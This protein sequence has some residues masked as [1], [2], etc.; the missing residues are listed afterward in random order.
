[1]N[2]SKNAGSARCLKRTTSEDQFGRAI[3]LATSRA[4]KLPTADIAKGVILGLSNLRSMGLAFRE[5]DYQAIYNLDPLGTLERLTAASES[6]Y[7]QTHSLS[8]SIA[9]L[10]AASATPTLEASSFS[11]VVDRALAANHPIAAALRQRH[12][13]IRLL[14]WLGTV[15]NKAVQ[16]RAQNGYI[17][18]MAM[19]ARDAFVLFRNPSEPAPGV[20]SAARNYLT[21]LTR[22]FSIPLDPGNGN[23][24]AVAYLDAV[25]HGLLR[26]H[27]PQADRA[28]D[29]VEKA[30]QH[31]VVM[32]A[33]LLDN[34]AWALASL[35]E[36]V[37]EHPSR[38]RTDEG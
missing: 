30:R 19:M 10:I 28:R 12:R 23:R 35:I 29:I 15:R 31:D 7:Q 22:A 38:F 4:A 27:Q 20:A 21:A 37:P 5:P 3:A 9:H 24:E 2:R 17:D 14:R 18:N 34:V 36:V 25:S 11:G 13:E 1:V 8:E 16:H 32:S 6:A 26:Q 33:A